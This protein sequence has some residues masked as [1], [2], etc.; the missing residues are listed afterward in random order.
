MKKFIVDTKLGIVDFIVLVESIVDG[1]FD[2]EGEYQ[3]HIGMANTMRL[4]YNKCVKHSDYDSEIP[5]D[6]TDIML[7]DKLAAD[8]EFIIE[9]NR[10]LNGNDYCDS[11]FDFGNANDLAEDMVHQKIMSFAPTI[12]SL[13]KT[14]LSV[15]ESIKD[16]MTP[17]NLDAATSIAKDVT[18]GKID[19][20]KIMNS[21]AGSPEFKGIV[22]FGKANDEGTKKV[23]PLKTLK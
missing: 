10:A 14:L 22:E 6:F 17:E 12:E 13:K 20:T 15:V 4:F 3:P 1:Y 23:S 8:K 21:F 16:V 19:Y 5:H 9:Y 11:C 2:D 7:V 18:S